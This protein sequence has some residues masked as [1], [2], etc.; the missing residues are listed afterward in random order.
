MFLIALGQFLLGMGAGLALSAVET[1]DTDATN[2]CA[3][4]AQR[5]V[6]YLRTQADERVTSVYS[7]YADWMSPEA[8]AAF[9][10]RL[11]T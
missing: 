2:R 1:A 3:V 8:R 10:R 5:R 4:R 9:E 7:R 6:D 11:T